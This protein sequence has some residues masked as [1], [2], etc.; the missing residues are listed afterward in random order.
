MN[1]KEFLNTNEELHALSNGFSEVLCPWPPRYEPDEKLLNELENEW[2]YYMMG[3]G[4][5]ILAWVGII[6][7]FV[8]VVF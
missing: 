3:R 2:H 6:S 7:L 4:L 5:G 8:K 1:I